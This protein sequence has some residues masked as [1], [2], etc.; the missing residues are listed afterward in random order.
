MTKSMELFTIGFTQKTAQEFF[1]L[2]MKSGVK[3]VIDTRI[4]NVSQLAGFAKQKDLKYF[5]KTIGNIEYIHIL[6][7]APTK[8]LLDDY[9]K[10][11]ID[12]PTYETKFRELI[13]KRKIETKIN[14]Q[15]LDQS[16]LLCSEAT[17]HQCHRRLVAEYL[18]Q[19]LTDVI[20]LNH[21]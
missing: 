9:K 4:N 1:E 18:Q 16:C 8:E 19:K 14:P 5:L 21:L 6:D 2:L 7:F 3:T 13:K 12:W 10:K 17:P 15:I 11:R 20:N